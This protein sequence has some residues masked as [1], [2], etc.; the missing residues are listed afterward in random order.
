MHIAWDSVLV[1]F[2]VSFAAAAAVVVLVSF[3]L[4][5]LSTRAGAGAPSAR[6][7]AGGNTIIAGL[8]LAAAAAIV[9]YGLYL[10]VAS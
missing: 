6:I 1:V 7:G 8:C 4:V 2:V 3:A 5:A 10:I 9:L